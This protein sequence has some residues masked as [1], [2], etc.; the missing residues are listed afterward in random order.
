MNKIRLYFVDGTTIETIT[1]KTFGE[2]MNYIV[3][4]KWQVW[5]NFM[6][7]VRH[8]THAELLVDDNV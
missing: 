5:D 2:F 4:T 8:I 3:E 7:N 1:D 6:F